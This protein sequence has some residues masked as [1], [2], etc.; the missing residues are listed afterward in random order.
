MRRRSRKGQVYAGKVVKPD[1]FRAFVNFGESNGLVHCSQIAIK[2][3]RRPTEFLKDGREVKVILLRFDSCSK[4][5]LG[6]KMV[7]QESGEEAAGR[8]KK[9]AEG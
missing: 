5:R 8:K 9:S 7:D 2:R 6:S 1:T 4:V 3:L